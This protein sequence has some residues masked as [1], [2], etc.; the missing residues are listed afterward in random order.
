M[1]WSHGV[2]AQCYIFPRK[3]LYFLSG[4]RFPTAHRA[5][6]VYNLFCT[7]LGVGRSF[8]FFGEEL[9]IKGKLNNIVYDY[10]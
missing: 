7:D 2:F 8:F 5:P 3:Y 1:F 9:L 4:Q 10:M 6:L